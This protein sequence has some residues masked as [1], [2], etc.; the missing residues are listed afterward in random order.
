MN[1]SQ[2]YVRT[3]RTVV[4][5]GD[6]LLVGMPNF[7]YTEQ[8]SHT[9]GIVLAYKYNPNVTGHWEYSQYL[10]FTDASDNVFESY[11]ITSNKKLDVYS[12]TP[13]GN[14]ALLVMLRI[15]MIVLYIFI[16]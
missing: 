5:G 16:K 14:Y 6:W 11:A 9:P 4:S 15:G 12:M 10:T 1:M 3:I 2:S 8:S 7:S 13:D